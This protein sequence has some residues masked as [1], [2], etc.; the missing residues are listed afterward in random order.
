MQT[1]TLSAKN[2]WHNKWCWFTEIKIC[3]QTF[4]NDVGVHRMRRYRDVLASI[5]TSG[6]L[7]TVNTKKSLE[8]C[9]AVILTSIAWPM[10]ALITLGPSILGGKLAETER[11]KLDNWVTFLLKLSNWKLE[12]EDRVFIWFLLLIPQ[13]TIM[14]RTITK[15]P[16]PTTV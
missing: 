2:L 1:S 12:F 14:Q 7:L 16:T 15:F 6:K 10:V 8:L 13:L 9:S 4:C 3:A 5:I 11:C